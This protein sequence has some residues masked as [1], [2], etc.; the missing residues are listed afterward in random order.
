MP[1]NRPDKREQNRRYKAEQEE[2]SLRCKAA[3]MVVDGYSYRR[4]AKA[5]GRS[6][7]YAQCWVERLTDC[8]HKVVKAG[9]RRV[10]KAVRTMK[11]GYRE[12]LATRR[13]GPPPG[14][15]PK[16]DENAEAVAAA[17]KKHPFMGCKKLVKAFGLKVSP[18]TACEILKEM[19]LVAAKKGKP[20]VK[21]F[22]R[23]APN[24]MWQI[25]HVQVGGFHLLS[26]I[27]DH[28]RMVLSK[29]LSR[30]ST[31]DEVLEILGACVRAYGPPKEILS[32]HGV[33]WYATSGGDARFDEWC[34]QEGIKHVMGRTRR[35]QTQG[36]VERW[37]RSVRDEPWPDA[38]DASVPFEEV[39]RRLF[40]FVDFYNEVR[41]HHAKGLMT[42]YEAYH[43]RPPPEAA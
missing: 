31:T 25:D 17:K 40:E 5:V 32:D 22:E 19:G 39:E 2:Q 14:A 15:R 3:M 18:P 37:H 28:S 24:D 4:A 9:G 33:Q 6:V 43:G 42:P 12:L 7:G 1:K 13:R 10:K 16:R 26:V 21:R 11:K 29:N 8:V 41:P 34:G 20:P 38:R 27:D 35:P 36:K 30:T 23:G